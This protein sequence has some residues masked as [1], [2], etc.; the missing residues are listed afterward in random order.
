M[1]QIVCKENCKDDVVLVET[2]CQSWCQ[3]E[4]TKAPGFTLNAADIK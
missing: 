1:L 2:G 3:G 4:E